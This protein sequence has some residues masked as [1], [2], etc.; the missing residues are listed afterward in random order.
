MAHAKRLQLLNH[1]QKA[2]QVQNTYCCNDQLIKLI[3]SITKNDQCGFLLLLHRSRET[4]T[5]TFDPTAHA[6][7][8][9]I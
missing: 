9:N 5:K 4:T 1:Y 3:T 2:P 6:A 8:R 7:H